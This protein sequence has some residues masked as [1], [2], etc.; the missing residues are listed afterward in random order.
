M[1]KIGVFIILFCAVQQFSYSQYFIWV[2]DFKTTGQVAANAGIAVGSE[3]AINSFASQSAEK[4]KQIERYVLGI[5]GALEIYRKSYENINGFKQD[6]KNIAEIGRLSK[7]I[8]EQLKL[9]T[10]EIGK[11]PK[12][13][14]ASHKAIYRLTEETLQC[15]KTCYSL[16]A[17]STI[18]DQNVS[19]V[20]NDG[21]NWLNPKDRL[22][23]LSEMIV[24]LRS[25]QHTC[26]IIRFNS[27]YAK[28]WRETIQT[29]MP[30]DFYRLT[31]G[32]ETAD[33]I[34]NRFSKK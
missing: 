23:V 13:T 8:A 7:G 1:K 20:H 12:A 18:K 29:A 15:L 17:N 31:R 16:V 2:S 10:I 30:Y 24:R 25:I 9:A 19:N 5:Q 27:S 6:S 11:N 3:T 21:L 22:V 34:I 28:T 26:V 32:K 4:Q 33:R 14:I